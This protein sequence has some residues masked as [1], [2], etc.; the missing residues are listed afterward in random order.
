MGVRHLN[1]ASPTI[2]NVRAIAADS[3]EMQRV[4]E[5]IEQVSTASSCT[6]PRKPSTSAQNSVNPEP[7]GHCVFT[8]CAVAQLG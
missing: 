4:V 6:V 1:S 5:F 8:V 2:I 7:D 3:C